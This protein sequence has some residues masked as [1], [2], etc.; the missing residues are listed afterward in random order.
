MSAWKWFCCSCI[1]YLLNQTNDFFGAEVLSGAPLCPVTVCRNFA[2]PNE[3]PD[4]EDKASH[5]ADLALDSLIQI[6]S[7]LARYVRLNIYL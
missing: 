6:I 5:L 4:S 1:Y 7:T 2:C 3:P